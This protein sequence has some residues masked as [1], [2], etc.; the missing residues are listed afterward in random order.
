MCLN[1]TIPL[2]DLR[3]LKKTVQLATY[4]GTS[5][6]RGVQGVLLVL[7]LNV[8]ATADTRRRRSLQYHKNRTSWVIRILIL[9]LVMY[10]NDL[11][12]F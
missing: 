12:S 1:W 11:R 4:A 3:F 5:I 6:V 7:M 8:Y 2:Q 9:I 10:C